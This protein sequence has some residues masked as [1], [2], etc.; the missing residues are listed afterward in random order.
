MFTSNLKK[1]VTRRKKRVGRGAGSGKG[2][3]TAGRGQKG[4][5]SRSG[6]HTPKGFIGGQSPL[7]RTTPKL[8]KYSGVR[9]EK[10]VAIS[11]SEFIQK[12]LN[13]INDEA[14]QGFTSSKKVIIVGPKSY[15]KVDLKNVQIAKGIAVSNSLKSKVI[16]AGGKVE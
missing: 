1:I 2:F 7:N 9:V 12:G 16:E 5:R 6:N 15:A 10:P 8:G 3:H 4:Q 11:I 13:T 14:V